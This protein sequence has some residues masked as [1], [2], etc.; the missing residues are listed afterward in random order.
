MVDEM[1]IP[2]PNELGNQL[3]S[4]DLKILIPIQLCHSVTVS[5][6]EAFQQA[7]ERE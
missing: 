6:C 4:L 5:H 7:E 2:N 3:K 1:I